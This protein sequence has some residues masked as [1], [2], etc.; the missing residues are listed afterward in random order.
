MNLISRVRRIEFDGGYRNV[1]IHEMTDAEIRMLRA[2]RWIFLIAGVAFG[3]VT[4]GVFTMLA[5]RVVCGV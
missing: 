1:Q 3:V 5:A 4:A 2:E